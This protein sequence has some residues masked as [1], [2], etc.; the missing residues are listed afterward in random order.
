MSTNLFDY[1]ASGG[2]QNPR[3]YAFNKAQMYAGS[4][5]VQIVQF[6]IPGT[7]FALLPSNARL[8]TGTPPAGS[9][10]YLTEVWNFLNTVSVYKFHVDWN[11]I[12]LSTLTG[13]F[14][15]VTPTWWAQYSDVNG[16]VPT[17]SLANDTL[18][19]RLMMQ[20]QYSNIGGGEALLD[21]P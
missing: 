10:N 6:D 1:A 3:L 4:P 13:P 2:F 8:Q 15:T 21:H 5:T 12:S 18:Y 17:P 14:D 19:P 20:N 7:E 16:T 9:P 11:S